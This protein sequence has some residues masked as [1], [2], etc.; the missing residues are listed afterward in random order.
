MVEDHPSEQVV[1]VMID[2]LSDFKLNAAYVAYSKAWDEIHDEDVRRKLNEVLRSLLENKETYSTFYY[3]INQYGNNNSNEY[4][5]RGRIRGEKKRAWRT[6][7]A[8]RKRI[9]RH[10][11]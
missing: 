4:S 2:D 5:S 6:R 11:K 9:S 3:T 1:K 8:K 10:K 7:E